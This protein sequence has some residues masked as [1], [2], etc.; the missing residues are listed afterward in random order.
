MFDQATGQPHTAHTTNPGAADPVRRA[1]A[2]RRAARRRRP[3]RCRADHADDPRASRSRPNDGRVAAGADPAT[4][5]ASMSARA[6]PRPAR[7][8][9]PQRRR[10]RAGLERQRPVGRGQA[11]V[12][13][14]AKRLVELKPD[15]A[16]LF[17]ARPRA[18][19]R[20]GD[21]RRH[22]PEDRADGRPA[23]D[24]LRHLGRTL[25]P[26]RP[27]RGRGALS[28]LDRR[29]RGVLSG[30]RIARRTCGG[31]WS[32]RLPPST[33]SGPS[34]VTHGTAIR[35]AATA[36]LD[37]PVHDRAQ[38]R[39]GQRRDE[40]LRLAERSLGLEGLESDMSGTRNDEHGTRNETLVSF[41]VPCSVFIVRSCETMILEIDCPGAYR[42]PQVP[43][44]GALRPSRS[45]ASCCRRRRS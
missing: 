35:I 20:P 34:I 33:A 44:L 14:L 36:L 27:P 43:H 32:A 40:H 12:Q 17:N 8:D 1:Q 3:L 13:R 19:H 25:L 18:L 29:R 45:S 21:R 6:H 28:A 38:F 30:R 7:P 5:V 16:L 9:R 11:Q 10:H 41:R 39:A 42:N 24:E 26:R 23:R 31:A 37:V 22:R 4:V 15:R 2:L